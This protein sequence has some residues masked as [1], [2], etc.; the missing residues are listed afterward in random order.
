LKISTWSLLHDQIACVAKGEAD[1]QGSHE[2][3][4]IFEVAL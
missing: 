1:F 4:Q 3:V 2:P